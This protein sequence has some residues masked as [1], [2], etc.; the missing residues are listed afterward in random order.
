M[1]DTIT[2]RARSALKTIIVQGPCQL[3]A[4]TEQIIKALRDAGIGL[5]ELEAKLP[6]D[7]LLPPRTVLRR[8]CSYGALIGT[9]LKVREDWP[10][11]N[12]T[13]PRTG[14]VKP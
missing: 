8:G 7:V 2:L 12:V 3:S 10:L 5:Y 11:E 13:F 4:A 14:P 1:T 9:A 6:C